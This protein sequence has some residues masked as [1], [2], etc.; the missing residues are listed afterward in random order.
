MYFL[1][2]SPLNC[3]DVYRQ[4]FN[5]VFGSLVRLSLFVSCS[6]DVFPNAEVEGGGRSSSRDGLGY[7]LIKL[8]IKDGFIKLTF[9]QPTVMN[10]I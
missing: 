9:D 8:V 10:K 3:L 7:C 5:V 6:I 4:S 2:N 1:P